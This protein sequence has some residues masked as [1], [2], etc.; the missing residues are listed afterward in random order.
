VRAKINPRVRSLIISARKKNPYLGV[1]ALSRFLDEKHKIKL[2]KSSIQNIFSSRGVKE[3]KGRKKSITLYKKGEN[4]DC[5]PL[6]LR[7]FDSKFGLIDYAVSSLKPFF[8]QF[9]E[10]LLRK[11]TGLLVFR[12]PALGLKENIAA[13]GFLRAAGLGHLSLGKINEFLKTLPAANLQ[14]DLAGFKETRKETRTIKF[15][16][17]GGAV[18]YCDAAM[19]TFWRGDCPMGNFSAPLTRAKEIIT[20]ML[21]A[22][23]VLVNYTKSFGY[24]SPLALDFLNGLTKGVK[25]IEFLSPAGEAWEKISFPAPVKTSFF[26]GYHPRF[27]SQGAAY[28]SRQTRIKKIPSPAGQDFFYAS[29]L[30]RFSR[31][32]DSRGIIVNN[33]PVFRKKKALPVWC[34]MTDRKDFLPLLGNYLYFWPFPEKKFPDDLEIFENFFKGSPAPGIADYPMPAKKIPLAK[35]E[36]FIEIKNILAAAFNRK[37]P[38]PP[39]PTA[40]SSPDAAGYLAV[41]KNFYKIIVKDISRT[42]KDA[43]NKEGF[44]LDNKRI[45]LL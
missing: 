44:Y 31:D 23:A 40:A 41:G 3:R 1:R 16:F 12:V 8:P 37:M 42:L 5:F 18:S 25:E 33:I 11:I 27:L 19:T 39:V 35:A 17:E 29:A 24:L 38:A 26:V 13:R 30:A 21:S 43:F 20:R 6:L 2:S 22:K 4:Y 14:L 7:G 45:F 10:D 34:F 28:L 9:E 36:D 32:K 15:Y